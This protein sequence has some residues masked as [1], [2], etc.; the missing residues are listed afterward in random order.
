MHDRTEEGLKAL[1]TVT[2]LP[3]GEQLSEQG[4]VQ[5]RASPEEVDA[6]CSSQ[7]ICAKK[8]VQKEIQRQ[9]QS[10]NHK[11]FKHLRD[12]LKQN[13]QT[14]LLATERAFG[15]SHSKALVSVQRVLLRTPSEPAKKGKSVSPEPME[16]CRQ[17]REYINNVKNRER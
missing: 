8:S 3:K 17:V 5:A 16:N 11:R 9:E 6:F 15:P 4:I 13:L 12:F 14:R 2:C 10:H 1:Q 7:L